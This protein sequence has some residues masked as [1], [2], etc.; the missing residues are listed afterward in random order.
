MNLSQRPPPPLKDV[1][2]L[3]YAVPSKQKFYFCTNKDGYGEGK[4]N[5]GNGDDDD[6]NNKCKAL[7]MTIGEMKA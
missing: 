1:Y 6:E 7:V 2:I 5:S 3:Q 4:G